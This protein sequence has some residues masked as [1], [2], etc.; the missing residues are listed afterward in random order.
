M[1]EITRHFLCQK[2]KTPICAYNNNGVGKE[3]IKNA[4]SV[5]KAVVYIR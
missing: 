5:N 2:C 3:K 1:P 4:D